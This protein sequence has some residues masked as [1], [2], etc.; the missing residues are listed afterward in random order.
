V[1]L[2]EKLHDSSLERPLVMGV[3]NVTPDSFSDGGRFVSKDAVRRQVDAMLA[4]GAD[5]IDIG[6]ES[7]R[8]GAPEV[9]LQEELDRVLPAMEWVKSHCD[10]YVSVDTYKPQV[11]KESIA[12]S[13]D[14]IN[15][16]NALESD[17]AVEL[18]ADSGVAV[19]LMHK[20]GTPKNMQVNPVYE[21][22]VFNEVFKYLAAR[23][24]ACVQQGVKPEAIT[25]DPGFGFGKTLT[26]NI[27]LFERLEM[28]S[29]LQ[30]PLLVGVSRKRMIGELLGDVPVDERV[31]G[32]V[33]AASLAALK[34]AKILR[35]HDVAET[36]QALKV[37]MALL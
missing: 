32:S 28:F 20:K 23:A 29:E 14:M 7:T 12:L 36:V 16:I 17:G 21:N 34:G 37:T 27:E 26:H 33:A 3:L 13:V 35:V 9:P 25:L 10:A 8:P 24:D 11:M 4:A 1:T 18:V 30:Y 15:D 2:I 22:G 6:G 31:I 19:C 5:M